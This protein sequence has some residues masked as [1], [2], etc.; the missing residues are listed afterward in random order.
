MLQCQRNEVLN[1]KE[2]DRKGDPSE[3]LF[4]TSMTAIIKWR[5]CSLLNILMRSSPA[6]LR[7]KME[8]LCWF[9]VSVIVWFLFLL[10]SIDTCS[11]LPQKHHV[12]CSISL[13]VCSADTESLI[14]S[15]TYS[16][17]HAQKLFNVLFKLS[18]NY[19]DL[20]GRNADMHI[21]LSFC[22][23]LCIGLMDLMVW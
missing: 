8:I 10:G 4:Q 13:V 21:L 14:S 16:N 1:G 15:G 2:R 19:D 11:I 23:P 20:I 9:E 7:K 17:L 22:D 12:Y 6:R 5:Y 3:S 18:L